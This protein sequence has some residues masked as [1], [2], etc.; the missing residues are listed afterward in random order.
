MDFTEN[1]KDAN[2]GRLFEARMR[3]RAVSTNALPK[4]K[5]AKSKEELAQIR[6]DLLKAN[7]PKPKPEAISITFG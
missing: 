7:K 6:K 4:E 3:N 2:K 5:E 1:K